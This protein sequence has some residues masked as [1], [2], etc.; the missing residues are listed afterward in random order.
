M[1]PVDS[2]MDN[3][4]ARTARGRLGRPLSRRLFLASTA[5]GA[6]TLGL[7]ACAGRP[8]TTQTP[9][10]TNS[11]GFPRTLV[12]REGTATIPGVPQRVVAVG[13]QRDTDTALALGVTPIAMAENT[14]IPNRIP[15]W[16][17]SELTDPRPEFLSIENGFPFEKIAGLRPDLILA[18][19]SQILTDNYNRLAQ[20]APTVSYID[21]VSTDTWQQRTTLLGSALGRDEQ[22]QKIVSDLEARIEQAA[23][24][25]PAFADKTFSFNVVGGQEVYTVLKGDGAVT[26]LEQLGLKISPEAAKQ[27]NAGLPEPRALVSLENL[28]VLEADVMIITYLTDNDRTF[29]ESNQVFQQLDAVK[30]GNYLPLDY[31]VSFALAYLS[32]LNIPYA[33]DRAVPAVTNVLA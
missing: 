25:N 28:G 6:A 31:L 2:A 32:P 9:P 12:G 20:I 3:L 23:Q 26:F 5:V 8:T 13:L 15:P 11:A 14:Y 24:S 16:V 19:D 4:A 7:T 17:E 18:T 27:L 33:L 21:G 1:G 30:N 29:L 10:T 22:A